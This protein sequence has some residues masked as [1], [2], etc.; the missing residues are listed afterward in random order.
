MTAFDPNLS[1]C[2]SRGAHLDL[3]TDNDG[4]Q[5][6][7]W[8]AGSSRGTRDEHQVGGRCPTS[9]AAHHVDR[10][11]SDRGRWCWTGSARQA[12]PRRS[13]DRIDG[14]PPIPSVHGQGMRTELHHFTESIVRNQPQVLVR[15]TA[16]RVGLPAAPPRHAGAAA[17]GTARASLGRCRDGTV[18]R[19]RPAVPRAGCVRRPT[20]A[21]E[22]RAPAAAPRRRPSRARAAAHGGGCPAPFARGSPRRPTP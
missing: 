19:R 21:G 16:R 22:C 12:A 2:G 18:I 8:A 6:L 7:R 4:R 20:C 14:L 15:T 17:R 11:G 10:P 13:D 9:T 1:H 3:T 5:H